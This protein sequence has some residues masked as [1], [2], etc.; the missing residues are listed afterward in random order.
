[1]LELVR[2]AAR[3]HQGSE[4]GGFL[5]RLGTEIE[6]DREALQRVMEA[7]GARPQLLKLVLAW[8]VEKVGRLKLNGRLFGRSPLS[9][10]IELEALEVGIYGKLLLWQVLRDVKPPGCEAVDL[11]ALIA[12][13]QQQLTDVEERRLAAGTVLER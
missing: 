13:A 11:D 2:R 12:R 4:L 5:A 3:E 10:F 1:M 9:P 7:A 8:M 6:A